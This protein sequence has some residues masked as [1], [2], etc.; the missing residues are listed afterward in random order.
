[1][2]PQE[3][4]FIKTVKHY[5]KKHGRHTLPWR[6]TTNPYHILVS[7]MMLQ[8]TQV[9]RVIPKYHTFIQQF[10]SLKK[11][12]HARLGEVLALWQGLGYN[13]RA[14]ML[15]ECAKVAI[16]KYNGTLPERFEDLVSLPGVG[17]Y[18]AQAVM[19]FAYNK[20][21]AM[22][23]TNIRSVY[24]HHFFKDKTNISDHELGEYIVRTEDTKN[25]RTWYYALMDYGV[26]IKKTF[27]NPNGRST[28]YAKQS[29]FKGSD[30]EIRGAI[31]RHLTYNTATRTSLR[32]T[33][34]QFEDIRVDAALDS[35]V[36]EGLV[37]RHNRI[38][39]LP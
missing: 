36:R 23:E 12:A 1:M 10:P 30:R 27:G 24:L 16:S 6:E 29:T 19:S 39:Q 14:K 35:L 31:V 34:S 2:S 18:T 8:Q 26:Y 25:P 22:I 15:H 5:Y 32:K 7:E 20:P 13:R 33:F 21:G 9:D 38:F 11:L 4:A 28:Q 3:K 17:P 37:L